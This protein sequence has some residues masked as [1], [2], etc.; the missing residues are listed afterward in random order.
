MARPRKYL[1]KAEP[2]SVSIDREVLEFLR[3]RLEPG[4]SL[5]GLINQVL[6]TACFNEVEYHTLM[7]KKYARLLNEHDIA[8]K[9]AEMI[10]EIDKP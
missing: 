9:T 1:S 4:Q 10:K 5:S 6:M 2:I 7:M 8:R 3:K